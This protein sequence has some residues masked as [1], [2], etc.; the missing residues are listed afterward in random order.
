[1]NVKLISRTAGIGEFAGRSI[2]EIVIGQARVSTTKSGTELFDNPAGL[3][4]HMLLNGHWSPFDMAYLGFEI[5][6]SR[7][8]SLELIRHHSIHVQQFSQRYAENLQMEPIELRLQSRNN[9]QSSTEV[10][11]NPP[12]QLRVNWL[13]GQAEDIYKKLIE[14]GVAREVARFVLPETTTTRLYMNGTIRSWITFLNVRLHETAQREMNQI[15]EKIA[16]IFR[17]ECPI[18]SEALG[19]FEN[20]RKAHFLDAMILRKYNHDNA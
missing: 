14:N 6:T 8:I 17:R 16:D 10:Y 3:I 18:I 19:N 1:M 5:E 7:A 12:L 9:R 4:R 2:D 15:A 20:A 13:L 11:D